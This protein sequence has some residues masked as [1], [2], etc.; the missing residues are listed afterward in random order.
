MHD[1]ALKHSIAMGINS[2]LRVD[3][4]GVDMSDSLVWSA[5]ASRRSFKTGRCQPGIFGKESIDVGT[6]QHTYQLARRL[7]WTMLSYVFRHP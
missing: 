6:D 7:G 1:D 2:A 4:P 5:L 3:E